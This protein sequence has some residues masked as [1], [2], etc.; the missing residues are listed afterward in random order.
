VSGARAL[1]EATGDSA[2]DELPEGAKASTSHQ[3]WL[4]LSDAQKARFI[5]TL[6]EPESFD[7]G[8]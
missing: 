3:E 1:A 2:Y 7:D 4:W 8:V 6:T 5:Q